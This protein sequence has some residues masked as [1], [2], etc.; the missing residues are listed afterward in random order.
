[1][2]DYLMSNLIMYF[3]LGVGEITSFLF[4]YLLGFPLP[5]SSSLQLFYYYFFFFLQK[6]LLGYL[7]DGYFS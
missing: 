5:V 2:L 7:F 4:S 6:S 1:M 3:V